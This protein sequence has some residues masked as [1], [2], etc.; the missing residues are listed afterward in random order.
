MSQKLEIQVGIR[1][2]SEKYSNSDIGELFY[3]LIEVALRQMRIPL[4]AEYLKNAGYDLP[5]PDTHVTRILSKPYLGFSEKDRVTKN[6]T[7][8]QNAGCQGCK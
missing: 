7:D 2:H 8:T 4:V 5:K 6:T 3:E 1:R